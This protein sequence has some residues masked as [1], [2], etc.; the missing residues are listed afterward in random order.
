MLDQI[1]MK[2]SPEELLEAHPERFS[3]HQ[4]TMRARVLA[5]TYQSGSSQNQGGPNKFC[6]HNL[7]LG[8]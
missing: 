1:K 3:A 7:G 6:N 4:K 8:R 2:E 5:S